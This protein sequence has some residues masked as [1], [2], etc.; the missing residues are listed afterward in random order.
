[1]ERLGFSLAGD[2][3]S[4]I[5]ISLLSTSYPEPKLLTVGDS[6][7]ATFSPDDLQTAAWCLHETFKVDF[8]KICIAARSLTQLH[9]EPLSKDSIDALNTALDRVN[10]YPD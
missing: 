9:A 5:P 4:F 6:I 7:E 1:M 10:G 3:S 8:D 2:S